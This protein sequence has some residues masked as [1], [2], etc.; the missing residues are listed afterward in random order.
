MR[1][2]IYADYSLRLL[3]YL[4]VRPE[5]L[6]TIGE[7]ADTYG[8]SRN[9][10]TKVTHQLGVTGYVKTVRGKR[11][12][13][14]L[15][16]PAAEISLGELVRYVEPDMAFVPCFEPLYAPCPIVPAC[17]LRSVLHEARRAFLAVLDRY[18]LADL[19]GRPA[20]LRALLALPALGPVPS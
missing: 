5:G 8:I 10:L 16:R 12:G 2:T 9:H 14:R 4:A 19:V 3:M 20:E 13:L 18:T 11:G 6:A 7:I 15:S 1:L 17:G